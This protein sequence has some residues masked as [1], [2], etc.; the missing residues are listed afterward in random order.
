ME[1]L[2][3]LVEEWSKN[4]GL[5]KSDPTKQFLKVTEEFG[6]IAA[7]L[8][9]NDMSAIEDGIGDTVVTLI[10]L[11]QQLGL[12]LEQCLQTAYNEIKGRTGEMV[13]GVFVK[14]EDLKYEELGYFILK[15]YNELF[16]SKGIQVNSKVKIFKDGIHMF[17]YSGEDKLYI[18]NEEFDIFFEKE[19]VF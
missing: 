6:E 3:K 4:K 16:H 1:E 2:I 9:R 18:T 14:S 13:N 15:Q 19:N 12:T 17:I 5:D 7:G 10:I 8:A 11:S